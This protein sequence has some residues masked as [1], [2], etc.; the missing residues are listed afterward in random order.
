M[1]MNNKALLFCFCLFAF[2]FCRAQDD[3]KL[4]TDKDGIRT[5][6]RKA[7]DSRINAIKVEADF[8]APLSR[9]AF[10]IADVASYDDWVFNSSATRL[11]KQVSPSELYY[12]SEIKFP[13]PAANRDF[14]SHITIL[15][16][17]QTKTVLINATNVAGWEPVKKNIVRINN[18]VGKW[19][20]R[21]L[22]KETLNVVYE[23]QADPGGGLPAWLINSFSSTGMV[24]TFKN[25]RGLL[26][27]KTSAANTLSF[28]AN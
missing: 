13:W 15:Q 19:T 3:W 2:V 20:I 21:P 5:Y 22:G 27:K 25:L 16:D 28:I 12:Y 6:S 11:L 4:K 7:E 1:T 24:E 10:I 23:L 17:P 8:T 26:N 18:S 9:L 14:V